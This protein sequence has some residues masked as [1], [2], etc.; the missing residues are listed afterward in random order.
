MPRTQGE[1]GESVP[2][3]ERLSKCMTHED[4]C[5]L[6]LVEA[7]EGLGCRASIR[8]GAGKLFA[9]TPLKKV[10]STVGQ[11]KQMSRIVCCYIR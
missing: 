2:L 11:I 9:S 8:I 6:L 3:P 7:K 1:A 4:T 5:I 10:L